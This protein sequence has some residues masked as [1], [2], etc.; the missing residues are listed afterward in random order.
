VWDL[1]DVMI[2]DN[3]D[4]LKSKPNNKLSVIVDKHYNEDINQSGI[5]VKTIK[6]VDLR[7]LDGLH[8]T[9]IKGVN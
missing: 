8:E 7:V 5:R 3:P 4:I 6:E 1:V 9:L 2:T